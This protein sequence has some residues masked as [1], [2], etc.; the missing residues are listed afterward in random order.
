VASGRV[1]RG[2][3]AGPRSA[4][5]HCF[6]RDA[7]AV[8]ID[9]ADTLRIYGVH[10]SDDGWLIH[11]PSTQRLIDIY[12][13]PGLVEVAWDRTLPHE[14]GHLMMFSLADELK[15][16]S[17][18]GEFGSP[19][20]DWLDEGAAVW[21]EP[22]SD[23]S[24]LTTI[25][26]ERLQTPSVGEIV[27]AKQPHVSGDDWIRSVARTITMPCLN[28]AP[29]SRTRW[30]EWMIVTRRIEDRAEVADTTYMEHYQ[31]RGQVLE[32]HFNFYS[33][34]LLRFIHER[35]GS[36]AVVSLVESLAKGDS[37]VEAITT[38]PGLPPT[39]E[40]L[41]REWSAWFATRHRM[42]FR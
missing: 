38:A 7:P 29:C 6:G 14:I 10:T 35:G 40:Q 41:E 2:R 28:R 27:G 11:W 15:M 34:A 37:S 22:G 12:A 24:D 3:A 9:I 18:P 17:E 33:N 4:S 42:G 36:A 16:A 8:L 21:M 25:R 13:D 19:F 32:D 20:P 23:P 1:R 26:R 5:R 31:E 30:N 39:G